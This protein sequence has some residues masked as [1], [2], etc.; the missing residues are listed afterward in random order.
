[1]RTVPLG[2]R[3]EGCPCHSRSPL[4]REGG[5]PCRGTAVFRVPCGCLSQV[6]LPRPYSSPAESPSGTRPG[7]VHTD[8]GQAVGPRATGPGWVGDLGPDSPLCPSYQLRVECMLLCEGAAVALDLVQPKA[9]LVLAACCSEWGAQP[10]A[11]GA[12][13]PHG[14][15]SRGTD[16]PHLT[17]DTPPALRHTPHTRTRVCVHR[18]TQARAH[19]H[20]C[21]QTQAPVH[22]RAHIHRDGRAHQGACSGTPVNAQQSFQK[23]VKQECTPAPGQGRTQWTSTPMSATIPEAPREGWL[24]TREAAAPTF[25]KIPRRSIIPGQGPG[26]ICSRGGEGTGVQSP[27]PAPGGAGIPGEGRGDP[28][29]ELQTPRSTYPSLSPGA[30]PQACSPA[31]GCPSSAS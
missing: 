19:A 29:T 17:I 5:E 25:R 15:W 1:M 11:G 4:L 12:R 7:N 3:G 28:H 6:P 27:G 21:T 23:R 30:L 8:Q 20:P 14:E 16:L 18:R 22:A 24:R 31:T 10:G 9:Q 13:N 26:V 2:L